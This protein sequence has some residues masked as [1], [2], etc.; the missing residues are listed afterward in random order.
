MMTED[1]L[2]EVLQG[3]KVGRKWG[4]R[5]KHSDS[6]IEQENQG[7][8]P[9]C[10]LLTLKGVERIE[11][12]PLPEE[13]MFNGVMIPAPLRVAP[14]IG[15]VYYVARP[16]MIGHH[17]ASHWENDARDR[18]WLERGLAHLTAEAAARHG[19]AMTV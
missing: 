5:Y 3:M 2:I 6:L 16:D 14:E 13:I 12:I 7:I 8:S 11:L 1:Q 15:T 9:L 19:K 17:H 18:L 10:W 4:V